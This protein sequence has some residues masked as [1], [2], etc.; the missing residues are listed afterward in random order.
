ML[1]SLR[2]AAL[3]GLDAIPVDVEVDVTFGLPA[4]VLV[5]LPDA[6]VRESRDRVR[7]AIRNSGFEFPLQARHGQPRARRRPQG[8]HGVRPPDR[9]RRPGRDRRRDD[10]DDRRHAH[11]RRAVARWLD[12]AHARR[13][14]GR[15]ACAASRLHAPGAAGGQRGR[16]RNGRRPHAAARRLAERSRG[17][18]ERPH[19]RAA[20]SAAGAAA[21]RPGG[22]RPVRGPRPAPGATGARDRRGRRP[23]PADGRPA[24]RGQDDAGAA[25]AGPAA[26][27]G[28]RRGARSDDGAFGGRVA[29]GQRRADDAP[30]LPGAASHHLRHGPGR[31]RQPASAWRDQPRA[32]RRALPRRG[33][34]IQPPRA[35]GAAPTARA[36]HHRRR[37]RG[38][39]GGLPGA[40]RAGRGHESV[41]VRVLRRPSHGPAPARRHRCSAMPGDC[42]GRCA[43]G[44]TSSCRCRRCRR[45]RSMRPSRARVPRRSGPGCSRPGPCRLA[46]DGTPPQRPT[47]RPA[48]AA[49]RAASAPDARTTLLQAV[50]RLGLSARAYYRVLRV[51]R[52]IADLAGEP[53]RRR[54]AT[55]PRPSSSGARSPS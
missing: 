18:A 17:G 50:E 15:G 5:G 33:A 46:R 31:R 6:S 14:V 53:S 48:P 49:R 26:A 45:R 4:L 55:S 24:R 34:G 20:A 3:F 28:V 23:Q 51:A 22:T 40:V 21:G 19:A 41:P 1:A 13:A 8:R 52:T 38:A 27:A 32:S 12:A 29:P 11:R 10:A 37:A 36:R 44:S 35:R 16:G 7:S 54:A 39:D 43:T 42:R 30:A 2:S 25:P 47:G 9:A